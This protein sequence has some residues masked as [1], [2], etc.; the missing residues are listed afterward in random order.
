MKVIDAIAPRKILSRTDKV[1]I[2]VSLAPAFLMFSWWLI[3]FD[4]EPT[5]KEMTFAYR[6]YVVAAN[7][8]VTPNEQM[9]LRK[10][11]EG[12]ELTRQHCD[13]VTA[14]RYHCTATVL[15]DGHP[16]SHT[17]AAA[18]AIYTRDFKGWTFTSVNTD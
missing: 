1:W 8:N 18:N 2:G 13:E 16:V 9:A 15:V 14:K 12:T 17:V 5:S 7:G 4:R 10:K 3:V 6:K 11:L